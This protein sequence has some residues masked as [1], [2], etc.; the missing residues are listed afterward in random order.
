[1]LKAVPVRIFLAAALAAVLAALAF[2]VT[3]AQSREGH[4]APHGGPPHGSPDMTYSEIHRFVNGSE[5]VTRLDQGSVTAAAS[6][7]LTVA[8]LDG[9]SVDVPVDSNTKV[10]GSR[11]ITQVADIP[12]GQK[13]LTVREGSGAAKAVVILHAP[14]SEVQRRPQSR[15]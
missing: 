3:N 15:R 4:G 9:S 8:E 7:G 6:Q 2:S 5:V 1:M 12:V 11:T 13:V 10:K 14:K